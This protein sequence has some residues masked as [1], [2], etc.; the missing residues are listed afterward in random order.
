[1][2][3][4]HASIVADCEAGQAC[5]MPVRR[6]GIHCG[7]I[8][9]NVAPGLPPARRV[10]VVGPVANPLVDATVHMDPASCIDC[11]DAVARVAAADRQDRWQ[12]RAAL[13]YPAFVCL[14]AGLGMWWLGTSGFPQEGTIVSPMGPVAADRGGGRLLR[15]VGWPAV[16]GG[17][18]LMAAAVASWWQ[19][20]TRPRQSGRHEALA[21][22]VRAAAAA[23]GLSAADEERIVRA[24][25]GSHAPRH[26]G[27]GSAAPPLAALAASLPDPRE[28]AEALRATAD[29]YWLLD[30]RRRQRR[31]W[32]LPACGIVTAGFVVLLYGLAMFGPLADCMHAIATRVPAAS[33]SAAP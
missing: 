10:T 31:Q 14:L 4:V 1:M 8:P 32:L 13:A 20:R 9:I 6:A 12:T 21:C 7:S 25:C 3:C 22:E 33:G 5:G 16:G 18:A 27:H 19:R 24:V 29:F 23:A 2:H 28:R 11:A 17:A 15:A 30:D 26:H